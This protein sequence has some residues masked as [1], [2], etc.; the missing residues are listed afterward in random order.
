MGFL[1]DGFSAELADSGWQYIAHGNAKV[2]DFEFDANSSQRRFKV[3]AKS[4]STV[5]LSQVYYIGFQASDQD[6]NRLD[7]TFSDNG[8]VK[9]TI[10][11][12]FSGTVTSKFYNST[13]T[14]VGLFIT[15][16]TWSVIVV[17][18]WTVRRGRKNQTKQK[19][20]KTKSNT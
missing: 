8:L 12:E 6:G 10:P 4:E 7:T 18:Y 11:A 5:E 1:K 16:A 17:F 19:P 13:V 3:S 9:I 15:I 20:A 2:E 14:S